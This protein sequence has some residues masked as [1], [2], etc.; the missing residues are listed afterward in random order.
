MQ[1]HIATIIPTFGESQLLNRSIESVLAQ[2]YENFSIFVCCDEVSI[3]K[4]NQIKKD[5]GDSIYL[6]GSKKNRIYALENI[7]RCMPIIQEDSIIGIVDGDDE[8][9][10]SDTFCMINDQY[11]NG[12]GCVWT[13]HNWDI[14]SVNQ[15]CQLD[16]N[17]SPYEQKWCSSHFRTFL[18]NDFLKINKENFKDENGEIFKRTYDQALMLPILHV[19]LKSGRKT[20]YID[21]NC[22]LYRGRTQW[23]TEGNK[24]QIQIEKFIRAR[25]YVE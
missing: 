16:D 19:V 10:R 2:D 21:K 20:K 11:N 14:N 4:E 17:I 5:Y 8:L 13:A 24:Y 6:I 1:N 25:G 18:K 12:Y 7:L 22:Y 23:N 3:E 15:S 9:I